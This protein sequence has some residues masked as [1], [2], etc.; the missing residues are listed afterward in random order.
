MVLLS[1]NVARALEKLKALKTGD[2]GVTDAIVCGRAAIPALRDLLFERNCISIYQ[3]RCRAVEALAALGAYDVLSDFLVASHEV[4]DPLQRVG[5]EAVVNAAALA[6]AHLREKSTYEL[7]F[8]LAAHHPLPGVIAAL[9]VF[10]RGESIPVLIE[11][12]AE[13]D[14]RPIAAAALKRLGPATRMPLVTTAVLTQ[15][16][17]NSESSS[18]LRRRRAALALLIAIGIDTQHWPVLR[19][20]IEETDEQIVVLACHLCLKSGP[21]PEKRKAVSRLLALLP[22]ADWKLAFEIEEVLRTESG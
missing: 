19:H 18:S 5:E 3:P 8:E 16:L 1:S 14:A 20:L 17:E 21:G 7:L 10:D 13:D 12:L 6:L 9:A 4:E 22:Q 15:R 2:G 11:A